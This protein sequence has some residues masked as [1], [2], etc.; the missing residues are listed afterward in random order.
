MFVGMFGL[1]PIIKAI[2]AETQGNY[3]AVRATYQE[4]ELYGLIDKLKS[5]LGMAFSRSAAAQ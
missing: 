2:G 3:V 5:V 1:R 4:A